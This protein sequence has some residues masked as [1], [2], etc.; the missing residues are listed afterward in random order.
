MRGSWLI[1][2]IG[3][4]GSAV[5]SAAQERL[6]IS[7]ARALLLE[8][9]RKVVLTVNRLPKYMCTETVDR[10]TFRPEVKVR[11]HSCDDLAGRRKRA[12]WKVRKDASDRLRLD[13]AVSRE[14]EMYSWAGEDRFGD[15]SL[16][17][18]VKRGAT[19]TGT[20]A[21]FLGAIFGTAAAT[22]TYDGNVSEGG[23]GLAA[24]GF[25]VPVEKS[26]YSVGNKQSHDVV[27][28]DGTFLVDPKSFDL[29]RLIIRTGGLPAGLRACEA[30]TTLEY[31]EVR[32]NGTE[33]LLPNAVRLQIVYEDGGESENSTV[34][35]GCHEFM[36]QS[37]LSFDAPPPAASAGSPRST[38]KALD[39]PAGLPFR[40][41]FTGAIDTAKAAAGDPV[42]AVLD[43][44]IK[45]RHGGILVPKGAAITGRIVQ[46][47]RSYRSG[48]EALTLAFRLETIEAGGATEP[49][50][51]RLESLVKR[52]IHSSDAAVVR[53]SLGSFDQMFD[54]DDPS[55]G[56]LEF[57]NVTSDYIIKPGV[58]LDGIT[59][60]KR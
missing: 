30:T 60:A 15:G 20:F 33:F 8:V 10:S 6:N 13:V 23:R 42:K 21:A 22:F 31:G 32:L 36:G 54:A 40:F 37:S 14:N 16:A 39:L 47:Q 29:V 48:S 4:I 55:I 41:A 51:A 9:R 34:F 43:T 11:G 57:Q 35:S 12:D 3:L 2:L 49:F 26:N 25:R 7:D 52:S 27:A 18:L 46:I 58:E 59:A 17:D 38:P 53:Q 19:S 50:D 44:P 24:F 56:L 28:Y 45:E 5:C 1:G